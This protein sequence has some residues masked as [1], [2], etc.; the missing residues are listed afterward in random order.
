MAIPPIEPTCMSMITASG[1][2]SATRAAE[3]RGSASSSSR[4]EESASAAVTSLRT[5]GPSAMSSNVAPGHCTGRRLAASSYHRDM[6]WAAVILF[7]A[8]AVGAP[9]AA[10]QW[11]V[12][13]LTCSRYGAPRHPGWRL[14]ADGDRP[15]R[16]ARLA[17]R[18][19]PAQRP[20]VLTT[21][22]DEVLQLVAD[23]PFR[24]RFGWTGPSMAHGA[25]AEMLRSS[26]RSAAPGAVVGYRTPL[27]TG[28]ELAAPDSQRTLTRS[29]SRPRYPVWSMSSSRR[30]PTC[31]LP[32]RCRGHRAGRD[33]HAG[34]ARSRHRFRRG[35]APSR[36][37]RFTGGDGGG[38]GSLPPTGAAAVGDA[39]RARPRGGL[40]PRHRRAGG[41][42]LR[43]LCR[44]AGRS[45]RS[46]G[47]MC[48]SWAATGW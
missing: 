48:S 46:G 22:I 40:L 30:F 27:V 15:S 26:I 36:R 8:I 19:A 32:R 33:D 20:C 45:R 31:S 35:R 1:R 41:G 13:R 47:A 21:D 18:S 43:V 4:M 23:P 34:D 28:T 12:P 17:A 42:G 24:L 7:A 5:Q 25:A 3:R 10:A 39:C 44:R 16:R 29:W 9:S 6:R 14:L 11:E 38:R 37:G 2:S